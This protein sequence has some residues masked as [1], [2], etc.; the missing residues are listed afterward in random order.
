MVSGKAS[1]PTFLS[2]PLVPGSAWT[3]CETL[4]WLP[5]LSDRCFLHSCD[6][7]A[8]APTVCRALGEAA[9]SPAAPHSRHFMETW[10]WVLL[11][12]L[13]GQAGE[14]LSGHRFGDC[15]RLPCSCHK[16]RP[17]LCPPNL[18]SAPDRNCP[19]W[20]LEASAATGWVPGGGL[21]WAPGREVCWV[22]V[23]TTQQLA[24]RL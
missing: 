20:Q 22:P 24:P 1:V 13:L 16:Y 9:R 19:W 8:R 7:E 14:R 3:C 18:S 15:Q 5:A 21:A 11:T 12:I 4:S 17:P 10:P 6:V 2:T 23:R